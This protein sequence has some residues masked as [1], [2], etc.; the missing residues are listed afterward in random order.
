MIVILQ[1]ILTYLQFATCST[2]TKDEYYALY[3][4]KLYESNHSINF[5]EVWGAYHFLI[6]NFAFYKNDVFIMGAPNYDIESHLNSLI[7]RK[8]TRLGWNASLKEVRIMEAKDI[9]TVSSL[10]GKGVSSIE[11]R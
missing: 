1:L 8:F 7:I 5:D 2:L 4:E 3:D 9:C 10:T 11:N 6:E